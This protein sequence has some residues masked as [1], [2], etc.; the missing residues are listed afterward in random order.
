MN[1][2]SSEARAL[3]NQVRAHVSAPSRGQRLRVRH[4]VL[5]SVGMSTIAAGAVSASGSVLKLVITGVLWAVVGAGATAGV[6][7]LKQSPSQRPVSVSKVAQRTPELPREAAIA[8]A[9]S[10]AIGSAAPEG[11]VEGPHH[12]NRRFKMPS[13][14]K[15]VS[16]EQVAPH[17]RLTTPDVIPIDPLPTQRIAGVNSDSLGA[18]VYAMQAVMNAVEAQRWSDAEASLDA[19][20]RDFPHGAL[21][22]E[23]EVL[24]VTVLCEL[25]RVDEARF[26]AAA[27]ERRAGSSPALQQLQD[28]RCLREA[29]P[30][31]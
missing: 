31:P 14:R 28:A 19:Y 11:S 7:R 3:V 24:R 27:L 1:G 9:A 20:R 29:S 22:V 13:A 5:A 26:S 12:T 6:M 25:N 8:S 16:N 17:P 2:L 15:N 10:T 4:A 30:A 18:E 21:G 23:A